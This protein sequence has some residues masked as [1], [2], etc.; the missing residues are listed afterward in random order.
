[1]SVGGRSYHAAAAAAEAG[2]KLFGYIVAAVPVDQEFARAISEA[3]GDETVLLVRHDRCWP[4]RLPAD[5]RRGRR[6]S[7]G[8]GRA[9]ARTGPR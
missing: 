6:S 5:R 1:M 3:T 8:G 7:N 9:G 4:L 2:G